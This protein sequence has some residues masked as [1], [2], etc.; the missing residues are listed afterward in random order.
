[1]NLIAPHDHI[2]V[3]VLLNVWAGDDEQ[4]LDLS[5]S[6]IYGQ[7]QSPQQLVVVVDGPIPEGLQKT[8]ALKLGGAPCRV[9]LKQLPRNLGLSNARNIGISLCENNL[10]AVHDAD[11]VMHPDR[12]R[13]QTDIFNS[14]QPS[15]LGTTTYEFDV[16]SRLLVGQRKT[17]V[18]RPLTLSDMWAVNP[19]HHS[20]VLMSKEAIS[21][22][23]SYHDC[24]GAEDLHLWRRL[25]RSGAV[26]MNSGY[27]LQALGTND[28]LLRR[29]RI[30][31]ALFR[32]ETKLVYDQLTSNTWIEIVSAPASFVVRNC[33]R[34]LPQSKLK[35]ARDKFLRTV[36]DISNVTLDSYLRNSAPLA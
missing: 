15:V 4:M 26:V 9:A 29:R 27:I 35:T 10:I 20:S 23:G 17:V 5:I 16:G 14:L 11:D 6:S 19:I 13:I 12:L 34:M 36:D 31:R 30:N 24:P 8:L 21:R 22:V 28:A 32:G 1:M 7:S 25:V 33:F 3:S 18:N 2:G